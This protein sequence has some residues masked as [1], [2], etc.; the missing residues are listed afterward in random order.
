MRA[1]AVAAVLCLCPVASARPEVTGE[2]G[3]DY[4]VTAS[5]GLATLGVRVCV[6][7]SVSE[8]W[9]ADDEA[10]FDALTLP[11]GGGRNPGL[12]R[13]A[14]GGG[15]LSVGLRPGGCVEYGV[16]VSALLEDGG[17]DRSY[18]V[19]Q[20]LVLAPGR[21][22]LRPA[23]YPVGASVT[24]EFDLPPGT[25]VSV[26]WP[27]DVLPGGRERFRLDET[28]FRFESH[29]AIGRFS[30]DRV[31]AAGARFD[32]AVLDRPHEATPEGIRRWISEAARANAL[33]HGRFPRDT[34]QVIVQPVSGGR[35]PVS[36]GVSR[37]GGGGGVRLFLSAR[38]SDRRLVGEWV[39][40]HEL[41]HLGLPPV[42]SADA[43]FYE[44]FVTYY[45]EVCRTRA[46]FQS[47]AEGWQQIYE[48]FLRGRSQPT[49]NTLAE[50][51]AG[52]HD[53]HA[54]WPVYWGG[55]ALALRVDLELRK[56]SG[57]R[58]SLD[59]AM[60]FLA[61]RYARTARLW[62]AQELLGAL[63]GWFGR[64]LFTS[65]IQPRLT[66]PRQLAFEDLFT[67]MGIDVKDGRVVLVPGAPQEAAR[68][69]I[70]AAPAMLPERR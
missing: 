18:R 57:G 63:D 45:Q 70:M 32:L 26:P 52:M 22:L 69:A 61:S 21:W 37:M 5:P 49:G 23:Q 56:A 9:V 16:N 15:A 6:R 25:S 36:F 27:R 14:A 11:P 51:S 34:V 10:S 66:S 31:E 54:Y 35:D 50:D 8:R 64:P 41:L 38:A 3:W 1:F 24:I 33:L 53:S 48:G 62:T 12:R 13:D 55:C 65:T 28:A 43:W 67:A 19:G 2:A 4:R 30:I 60:R 46:G 7:G 47:E 59:D 42:R 44:G 68:R 58:T 29:V 20:D 17:R 39:G 40:V